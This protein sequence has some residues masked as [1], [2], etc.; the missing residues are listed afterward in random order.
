MTE[1]EGN[2]RKLDAISAKLE[3]TSKNNF[4]NTGK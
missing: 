1:K 2:S 4:S 3:P